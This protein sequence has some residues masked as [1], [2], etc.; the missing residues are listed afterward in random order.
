MTGLPASGLTGRSPN[1]LTGTLTRTRSPASAACW[2]VPAVASGPSSAASSARV[3]GPRELL[4]TTRYPAATL[5]R[6]T[7]PPI[8]PL[9]MMPRVAM[10][11]PTPDPAPAF[12][13]R[14]PGAGSGGGI[15]GRDPRLWLRLDAGVADG[16]EL[17]GDGD[18]GHGLGADAGSRAQ[19]QVADHHAGRHQGDRDQQA[20]VVPV[21]ERVHRVGAG[22]QRGGPAGAQDG[23]DDRDA[24]Q[25]GDLAG[26]VEQ[27]RGDA[28][29][30]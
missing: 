19:G 25:P 17:G 2:A 7:V 15:R 14:D 26:G 16:L 6:A 11:A 3:S 23:A 1:A 8:M 29:P 21:Q 12:R 10:T 27:R 24:E 20:G 5:S 30:D 4:T 28:G 9:P 22:A 18:R 13:G